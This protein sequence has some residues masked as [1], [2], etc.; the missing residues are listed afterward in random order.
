MLVTLKKL[1][2]NLFIKKTKWG[3]FYECN[4]ENLKNINYVVNRRFTNINLF[5]FLK[6]IPIKTLF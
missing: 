2:P 5:W 4:I 3:F 1:Y 6:K